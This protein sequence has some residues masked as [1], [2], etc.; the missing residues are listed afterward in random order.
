MI[1]LR[2][3]DVICSNQRPLIN[4]VGSTFMFIF[5]TTKIQVQLLR[6]SLN[7]LENDVAPCEACRPWIF[8]INGFLCFFEDE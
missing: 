2:Y 3:A 7:M 1:A 8:F 4:F 5:K 6:M